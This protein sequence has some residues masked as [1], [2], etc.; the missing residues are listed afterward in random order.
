MFVSVKLCNRKNQPN[1]PCKKSVLE[2][3]RNPCHLETI[4]L[5]IKDPYKTIKKP[6]N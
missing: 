1:N 5:A 6:Q 2:Y 4:L 3:W